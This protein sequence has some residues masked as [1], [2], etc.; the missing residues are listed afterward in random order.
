MVHLNTVVKLEVYA[1]PQ[2]HVN[3]I[4]LRYRSC[5]YSSGTQTTLAETPHTMHV[6]MQ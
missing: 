1:P 6:P 3:N 2:I 5:T 4:S